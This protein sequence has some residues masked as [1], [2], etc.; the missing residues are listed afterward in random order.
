MSNSGTDAERGKIFAVTEAET[1]AIEAG[2]LDAYLSL[3]TD[4]AVFFPQNDSAK[5]RDELRQ[6]LRDFLQRVAIKYADFNHGETIVRDDLACHFYTCGWTAVARSG[7]QPARMAFKGMHILRRQ[8]D[9]S[10]KISRS[11]WN[12]DPAPAASS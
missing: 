5:S 8:P 2:N 4:D 9:G 7:G 12:T 10:W 11:I 3:L 6:W 1:K